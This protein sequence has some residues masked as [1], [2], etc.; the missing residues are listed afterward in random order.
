MK[1]LYQ[2][3]N[4]FQEYNG[5]S[6]KVKYQISALC[7]CGMDVRTCHYEIGDN[8]ERLWMID[9][10]VLSNL[11]KGFLAKIK[12]R[13]EFTPILR[14]VQKEQIKFVYIRSYHNANPFTIHFVKRLK[15]LG[16]KVALEIPTYPYDQEFIDQKLNLCID[17][18]FRH[19]F[20]KYVDAIVTF[21]NEKEIFGQRTICI[22]N[23]IDFK[24]IPLRKRISSITHELHL[25]GVAEI[26]FWHGFD[27]IIKG[28]KEYYSLNPEYKVYFHIVGNLSGDRE[29]QEIEF[30]IREFNLQS[31]VFLYGA[32]HGEELD[33]LFEQ[34][35]FAIG[36]LGRHRSGICNI[37]TL[38]NREY[39]ARGFGFVYSETDDDFD[40]M[41]YVLKVP[42]NENPINIVELIDF[43]KNQSMLPQEIRQSILHLS[44]KEQM[45]KICEDKMF[46]F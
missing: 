37:K 31:Y 27:R 34:A 11:G 9:Q 14:Y 41:P 18:M 46:Q 3:F 2:I 19:T 38:K 42:A 13:I 45:K 10:K 44:W 15:K 35:D 28:L 24:A 36:S 29:Q 32:K 25:I 26:H 20:C 5:I 8:G 22:S 21:S 23:G 17:R 33:A 12:K 7:Q 6:K 1:T 4:G 43:C 39:A 16:V 40:H 30:P